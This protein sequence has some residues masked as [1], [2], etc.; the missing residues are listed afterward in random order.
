MLLKVI[1]P[2]Q[3]DENDEDV[4]KVEHEQELVFPVIGYQKNELVEK[5][6]FVFNYPLSISPAF[7]YPLAISPS[8]QNGIDGVLTKTEGKYKLT[9][10]LE[11]RGNNYSIELDVSSVALVEN[12]PQP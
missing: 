7:S 9:L 11:Y 10:K 3:S 8:Y 12:F 5:W 1:I 6:F 2:A 4:P